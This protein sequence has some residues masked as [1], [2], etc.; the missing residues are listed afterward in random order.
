M[1]NMH[2]SAYPLTKHSDFDTG[3]GRVSANYLLAPDVP[4]MHAAANR[5]IDRPTEKKNEDLG[6]GGNP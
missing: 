5:S 4:R 3:R 1:L 2:G 6:I